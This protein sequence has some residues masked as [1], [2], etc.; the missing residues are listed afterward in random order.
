MNHQHKLQLP[1]GLP[2]TDSEREQNLIQA[3]EQCPEGHDRA[4]VLWKLSRFYH[5]Q[6]H[7]SDL[8]TA[9]L[10]LMTKERVRDER[11]AAFHLAIGQKAQ[12]QQK[13]DVALEHYALGLSRSPKEPRTLYLLY[14]NGAHCRNMLGFYAEAEQYCRLAIATDSKRHEAYI[15]LGISLEG[16]RDVTG[17]AW[18]F[19]EALKANPFN[20]QAAELL[21]Q[22]LIDYP[23]L[24][25]QSPWI[26]LELDLLERRLKIAQ[27]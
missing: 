11:R 22:V 9:L 24:P 1:P 6:A 5:Y 14:N 10:D 2:V 17:A 3:L 4:E 20:L 27:L 18:C 15:N 16:Q 23:T 8:A 7:R 21:R 19:V 13:W 25:I 26:Q 12:G